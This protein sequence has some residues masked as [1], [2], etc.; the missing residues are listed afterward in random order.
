MKGT[1]GLWL[2]SIHLIGV[3]MVVVGATGAILANVVSADRR[4]WSP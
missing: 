4:V 2:T 1:R 3:G